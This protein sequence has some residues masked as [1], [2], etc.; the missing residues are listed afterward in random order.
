M[1]IF[2]AEQNHLRRATVRRA[3][4]LRDLNYPHNARYPSQAADELV[5]L[6]SAIEDIKSR[7]TEAEIKECL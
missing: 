7:L 1:T 2:T 5:N 6:D 4:V 3:C